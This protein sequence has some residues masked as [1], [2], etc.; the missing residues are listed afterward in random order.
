MVPRPEEIGRQVVDA[1][2]GIHRG[3]GPGLL[4]RAYRLALGW[5][6]EKRGLG[7]RR[8]VAVSVSWAGRTIEEAYRIDLL[9]EGLVII[10]CKAVLRLHEVHRRQ[11]LTYLRGADLRLG[12]LLN[13]GGPF[14]RDLL[15][16]VINDPGSTRRW[17]YDQAAT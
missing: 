11:V 2:V 8:E 12:F 10:D 9:V 4:P 6:L 17:L 1:A 15:T 16:R 7:V 3:L 5:E 13:F 14:M